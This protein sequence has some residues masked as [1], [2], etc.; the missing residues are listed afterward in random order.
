MEQNQRIR[1]ALFYHKG[2][3]C[4]KSKLIRVQYAY[5]CTSIQKPVFIGGREWKRMNEWQRGATNWLKGSLLKGDAGW[6]E[7]SLTREKRETQRH[8]SG[9]INCRLSRVG[10][11]WRK[12]LRT[13]AQYAW[14]G[15]GEAWK[16]RK[17]HQ[18]I[19][20]IG[21]EEYSRGV[22]VTWLWPVLVH[23]LVWRQRAPSESCARWRLE[24]VSDEGA[25]AARDCG[26]ASGGGPRYTEG[27]RCGLNGGELTG[28]RPSRHSVEVDVGIV[29]ERRMPLFCASRA[30]VLYYKQETR[31]RWTATGFL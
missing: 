10:R 23:V 17:K 18:P 12:Q 7:R 13:R 28:A 26:G 22:L 4:R 1:A 25:S 8:T 14:E 9:A 20:A 2:C 16:H 15:E 19:V 6:K 29:S 5:E 3:R 27:A 31:G 30:Q 21:G 24:C 11:W